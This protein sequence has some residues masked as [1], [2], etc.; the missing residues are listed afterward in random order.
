MKNVHLQNFQKV[1]DYRVNTLK[2]EREPLLEHLKNMDKHVKNLYNELIQ[3]AGL[4]QQY[5]QEK[6]DN[7]KQLK[8][9]KAK[10]AKSMKSASVSKR[11]LD[12]YQYEILQILKTS[13][14]TWISQLDGLQQRLEQENKSNQSLKGSVFDETMKDM[15]KDP[16]QENIDKNTQLSIQKE[17]SS[18][19]NYLVKQLGTVQ[20]QVKQSLDDRHQTYSSIQSTNTLLIN[21]CNRLR[22]TK[23][24]LKDHIDKQTKAY[25]EVKRELTSM[26]I[27]LEGNSEEEYDEVS[28]EEEQNKNLGESSYQAFY[29]SQKTPFAQY[30]EQ[31]NK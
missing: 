29:T 5:E 7:T 16:I 12:V 19:K 17:L 28:V 14:S 11:R 27:N 1:Y 31:K 2:E 22:D 20:H 8:D 18:Q 6:E 9:L 24:R 13:S 4:K 30:E 10:L 23:Q 3:E 25:R 15:K 26:G 21:E